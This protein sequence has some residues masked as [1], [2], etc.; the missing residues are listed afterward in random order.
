MISTFLVF[1]AFA[2]QAEMLPILKKRVGIPPFEVAKKITLANRHFM[3]ATNQTPSS[4]AALFAWLT[5]A[6][7]RLTQQMVGG[8][9]TIYMVK[10]LG[11]Q[12]GP[13]LPSL[14]YVINSLH[15]SFL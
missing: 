8:H 3:A 6:D 13:A 4:K 7:P 10:N 5:D 9:E 12:L 11:N 15:T 2:S 1:G 14:D